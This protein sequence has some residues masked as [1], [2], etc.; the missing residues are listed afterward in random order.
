MYSYFE[1]FT[2]D[3]TKQWKVRKIFV[4]IT[5]NINFAEI[6]YM[7]RK[8]VALFMVLVTFL[9]LFT[10]CSDGSDEDFYYPIYADPVSFDPQ[11]AS[12]N[13]SK[14]VVSIFLRR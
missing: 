13:A 9:C 10:A 7:F 1:K 6:K 3:F 11:I 12:D 5:E 14:I 2:K 8:S 4:I